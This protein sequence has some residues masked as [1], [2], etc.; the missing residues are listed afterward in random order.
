MLNEFVRSNAVQS[1]IEFGCGDGHQLSLATYPSYVGLDVSPSAIE[2][3]KQ[4]FAEDDT[5]SFFLY[6]TPHFVDRANVFRAELAMSLDVI[7]HLV[8]DEIFN[9]YM[10]HLFDA[11]TRFV[12][13]YSSDD[14]SIVD[15]APH[16]RHR[17]FS[18]WV[19]ENMPTWT[20]METV[21]NPNDDRAGSVVHFAVYE[22]KP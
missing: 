15:S 13:I 12:I 16:V 5:K 3:C 11:A 19:E 10:R 20:L 17:Q 18:T 2:R 22:Q 1:V 8:E 21:K 14:S 6:S 4:M 9:D 7:Y